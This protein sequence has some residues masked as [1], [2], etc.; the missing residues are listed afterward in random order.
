MEGRGHV[1]LCAHEVHE[2][3]PECRCE[4][5]VAIGHD[6]LRNAVEMNDVGEECLRHELSGV[7]V[8][9]RDEVAV[10][11][12]VVDD[13]EDDHLPMYPGHRLHE[14][15][16]DVCPDDGEHRQRLQQAGR[17]QVFQLVPLTSRACAHE[18]LHQSTHVW[19]MDV[20]A[21]AV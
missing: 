13:G 17:V 8:R 9:Q 11:A 6:G 15:H 16:A 20:A 18:V 7:R 4:H 14:V 5:R 10:H 21:E 19:K 3:A 12:E 1:Q 2:L